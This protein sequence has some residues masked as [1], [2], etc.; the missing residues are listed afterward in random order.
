MKVWWIV[1]QNLFQWKVNPGS[2]V[3]SWKTLGKVQITT[4][5]GAMSKVGPYAVDG[6]GLGVADVSG[7]GSGR[8]SM[9]VCDLFFETQSL[10]SSGH[11]ASPHIAVGIKFDD[12]VLTI[13]NPGAHFLSEILDPGSMGFPVGAFCLEMSPVLTVHCSLGLMSNCS[14]VFAGEVACDQSA[15]VGALA[16]NEKACPTAQMRGILV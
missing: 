8:W 14:G 3:I 6:D 2:S 15:L 10:E 11:L 16:L 12:N 1:T 7:R 4:P 9:P 13:L 5:H